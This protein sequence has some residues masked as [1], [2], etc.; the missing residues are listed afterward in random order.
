M[1][2]FSRYGLRVSVTAIL[3]I[4]IIGALSTSK[5]LD[6][7]PESQALEAQSNAF[8]FA[9]TGITG[10]TLP[11]SRF[12]G[13]AVLLVNTAS[14]CGF[15]PQ[16][17][18]LQTLYERYRERGLVVLGV[19]SNDFGGQEPGTEAEI[20][21]FCAVTFAV[22][23]PMTEKQ[24]VRGTGAHPLYAWLRDRLGPA[25]EPRWNFHKILI[26]RDGQP[27]TAWSSRTRPLSRE[28]VATVEG[29]LG[30]E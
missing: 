20:K 15:T 13:Q 3:C 7:R 27:V 16:Y 23:F 29:V 21:E 10:E 28:L 6:A 11:M 22:T 1:R 17:R 8:S 18:G 2:A 30:A 4:I 12:A 14:L 5:P 9:F 26:G 19:P 24:S 25:A